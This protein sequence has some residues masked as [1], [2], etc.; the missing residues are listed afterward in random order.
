LLSCDELVQGVRPSKPLK[1]VKVVLEIFKP[2]LNKNMNGYKLT[3][4]NMV[5]YYYYLSDLIERPLWIPVMVFFKS[6]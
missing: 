6:I 4:L 1:M 2:I 3:L 5:R